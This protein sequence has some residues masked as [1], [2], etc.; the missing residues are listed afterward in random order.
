[1]TQVQGSIITRAWQLFFQQLIQQLGIGQNTALRKATLPLAH[2]DILTLPS[3]YPEIVPTPGVGKYLV[4]HR[5]ALCLNANAAAYT[6]VDTTAAMNGLTVAYGDWF[7]DASTFSPLL[8]MK[9]ATTSQFLGGA[10]VGVPSA[11]AIAA[12]YPPYGSLPT[13]IVNITNQPLKLV[14]W[15]NSAGDFTGGDPENSALL[16]VYYTIESEP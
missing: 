7:E 10:T 12:G 1:M 9:L 15:N 4:V 6:N 8:L 13:G 2:A 5:W 14:A 3:I 11:A 16:N